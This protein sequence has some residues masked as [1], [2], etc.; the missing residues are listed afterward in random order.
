MGPR[1]WPVQNTCRR[2]RA[3][4]PLQGTLPDAAPSRRKV[5][6][7]SSDSAVRRRGRNTGAAA[8][9]AGFIVTAN[10]SGQGDGRV[11]ARCLC[12]SAR[13]HAPRTFCVTPQSLSECGGGSR[14]V[15]V[16]TSHNDGSAGICISSSHHTSVFDFGEHFLHAGKRIW[17]RSHRTL[18]MQLNNK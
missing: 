5:L 16:E 6:G 2:N 3:R 9:P 4:R 14:K 1:S 15:G 18:V 17:Y 8:D 10:T 7:I 12:S 13:G 11:C